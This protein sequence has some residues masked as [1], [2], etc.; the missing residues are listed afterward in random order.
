MEATQKSRIIQEAEAI[1]DE[2]V[3]IYETFTR[4][5]LLNVPADIVEREKSFL[6]QVSKEV[7]LEKLQ[8]ALDAAWASYRWT[9]INICS[10]LAN[11]I[12][13]SLCWPLAER[14]NQLTKE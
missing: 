9:K 13:M 8:A 5:K 3:K 10:E 11:I 2:F 4:R 6:L 14:I 7:N 1:A 12:Y